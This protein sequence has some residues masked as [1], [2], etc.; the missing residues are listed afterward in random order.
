M[1]M[2]MCC[3]GASFVADSDVLRGVR[4][5]PRPPARY[6]TV[7]LVQRGV[8][9]VSRFRGQKPLV[10]AAPGIFTA[11]STGRGH[12]A[13][14]DQNGLIDSPALGGSE[15]TLFVTGIGHATPAF[16]SFPGYSSTIPI[17]AGDAQGIATG[18]TQIKVP[19]GYG[20]DCDVPVVVQVGNASSQPGVTISIAQCI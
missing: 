6:R 18:V 4:T 16:L 7:T 5:P 3:L 13:S 17:S 2:P 19:I 11:D 20:T 12:A 14:V 9:S 15:I 10:A 8:T 1:P